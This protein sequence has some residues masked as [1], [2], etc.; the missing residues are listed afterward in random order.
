MKV[1]IVGCGRISERHASILKSSLSSDLNL[2]AVCD[3][4]KEKA[5]KLGK[6]HSVPSFYDMHQMMKN[7]ENPLNFL[8]SPFLF[9]SSVHLLAELPLGPVRDL[10][11][12]VDG[13]EHAHLLRALRSAV[14]GLLARPAG[15]G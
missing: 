15:E 7:V 5:D 13:L 3:I 12:R 14:L 4:N 10:H 6:K 2:V 11:R 1:A 8:E 9:R